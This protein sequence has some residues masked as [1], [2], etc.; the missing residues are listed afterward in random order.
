MIRGERKEMMLFEVKDNG[1]GIPEDV[2]AKVTEAFF[3]TK[4]MSE[5]TGLG[6]SIVN[7]IVKK[8]N[9]EMEIKSTAGEG[10]EIVIRLPVNHSDIPI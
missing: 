4:P 5:G 6:L 9:G 2:L 3:T 7:D 10:T 1:V 8:H